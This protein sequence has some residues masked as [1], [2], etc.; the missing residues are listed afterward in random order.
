ML[1]NFAVFITSHGSPFN[2]PS[3]KAIRDSGYTGAVYIVVDNLDETLSDYELLDEQVIVFDK[4]HYVHTLDIGMST[5]NPQLSAVL[6]ARAAV[7]DIARQMELK[8]FMVMDDDLYG[9]R[10]RYPVDNKLRSYPVENIECL[11]YNYIEFM[12]VSNSICLSFANDGSFIAGVDAILSGK[13]MERR[14]CHTIF[15]RDTE[16]EFDWKFAMNEDYISSLLYANTGQLMFTL[17]FVQR[18][19]RG[20]NNRSSSGMYDAYKNS[21]EFQRAFYN[22]VACPWT[23][24][25]TMYKGHYVVRVNKDSAYPK[26]ISAKYQKEK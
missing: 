3:L 12:N 17:P 22:T 20:M 21:T 4:M 15:L 10:Y 1:D 13:I 18:T 8:Y 7:E 16:K 11:I 2:I 24:K 25:P 23:C 26:I 9:F 6:Y 14:S 19:I 5:I